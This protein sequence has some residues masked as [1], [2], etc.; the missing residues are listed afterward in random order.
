M[1]PRASSA[2][3]RDAS[4]HS[5]EATAFVERERGS[6]TGVIK[7]VRLYVTV[8]HARTRLSN[9][10]GGFRVTQTTAYP[11]LVEVLPERVSHE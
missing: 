3:V 11:K 2:I 6:R 8:G 5:P 4:R 10:A 1:A 7:R 9:Q